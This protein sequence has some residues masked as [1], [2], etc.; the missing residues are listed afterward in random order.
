MTRKIFKYDICVNELMIFNL[1]S[2]IFIFV[3]V[4][5]FRENYKPTLEVLGGNAAKTFNTI[6]CWRSMVTHIFLV[7]EMTLV[8]LC[9]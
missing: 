4:A 5:A 8:F 9:D 7:P 6:R 1:I 3:H 2:R